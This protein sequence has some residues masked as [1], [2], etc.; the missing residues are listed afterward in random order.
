MYETILY[1]VDSGILTLTLN[2][3]EK[4][5]ASNL[6]MIDE[7]I[8]AFDRAD[9][10]DAVRAIIVT[11]AGRGFCAGADLSSGNAAFD[12]DLRE[13]KAALGSPVRPDGSI[14]YQHPAVR[15][16]A[17]RLTLRIFSLL[18]PI[19]AAING[20]A[21]GLGI[22]MTLPM[23]IRIASEEARF[24]FPFV[25]RGIVPDGASSWFLP[26]LVGISR[27]LE[28]C[29]TARL[30]GAAEA[31]AG[32]LVQSVFASADILPA[33]RALATEMV[34][35]NAP[36][37]VALTRQLLWRGLTMAEPIDSHR[38]ES[39]GIY[40]RGRSADARE[41][42][43]AYVEKRPPLFTGSVA[44]DIPDFYPWWGEHPYA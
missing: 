7:L 16:N 4:L 33:A 20:A 15:D 2:R 9:S 21:V 10:D 3:P 42:I 12:F 37:S 44:N 34:E 36:V 40:E 6:Q 11:G 30:F 19:I 29:S 35:G 22:T 32:G 17:G 23:D 41:G 38:I 1:N 26:R 27:A 5:N 18:K 14:N 25:R 43:A 24:S 39:W 31:K 28:W 8:H 13:D